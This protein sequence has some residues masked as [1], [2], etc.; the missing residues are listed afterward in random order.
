MQEST[1]PEPAM[2]P[3]TPTT[4]RSR[5][6]YAG[7]YTFQKNYAK[8]YIKRWS[9]LEKRIVTYVTGETPYPFKP[10]SPCL[11]SNTDNRTNLV[12]GVGG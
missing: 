10:F 2:T 11:S 12:T 9:E 4:R 6:V 5:T 3:V 7:S 8:N 1:Q